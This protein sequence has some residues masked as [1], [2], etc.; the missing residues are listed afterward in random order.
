MTNRNAEKIIVACFMF[1]FVATITLLAIPIHPSQHPIDKTDSSSVAFGFINALMRNRE[2]AAYSLVSLENHG[3]I[4]EWM[5]KHQSFS[6]PIAFLSTND[7][8][9]ETEIGHG[10]G[11]CNDGEDNCDW[12]YYIECYC[13]NRLT[14]RIEIDEMQI[15]RI[16]SEQIILD[17]TEVKEYRRNLFFSCAFPF[18]F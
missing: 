16:N 9:I 1:L 18:D 10:G 11:G 7:D 5:S 17:W 2:E 15:K 8:P 13:H 4:D 6:C 14:Y 12:R 3:R